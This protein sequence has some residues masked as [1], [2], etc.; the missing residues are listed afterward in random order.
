MRARG[1]NDH[2]FMVP[3]ALAAGLGAL[4]A[5]QAG[6]SRF[7]LSRVS[8]HLMVAGS[9]RPKAVVAFCSPYDRYAAGAALQKSK[10]PARYLTFAGRP[11]VRCL[12]AISTKWVPGL[13]QS[14]Q[15]IA[16]LLCLKADSYPDFRTSSCS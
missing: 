15:P 13:D 9:F 16:L 5:R 1:L 8:G 6:M 14:G 4:R 7:G 2:K 12:V 10:M 3:G 11:T